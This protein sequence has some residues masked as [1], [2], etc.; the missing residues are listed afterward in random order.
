LLEQYVKNMANLEKQYGDS[1]EESSTEYFLKKRLATEK[2][3]K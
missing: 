3:I 2:K 1:K